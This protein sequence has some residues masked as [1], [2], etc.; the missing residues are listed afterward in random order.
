VANLISGANFRWWWGR[1]PYEVDSGDF[2]E[3]TTRRA[4]IE[5]AID[6]WNSRSRLKF[7]PHDADFHWVRFVSHPEACQSK[8][9]QQ[10]FPGPQEIRC[11]L[12]VT[13]FSRGA[14][15]HEMC[16][17]AGLFHEH[18]RPDRDDYVVVV[19][20]DETNYG[21]KDSDDVM[22]V[23]PYDYLSIMH[24]PNN[25]NLS[26]PSRYTPGQRL[27]LSYLDLFAL[28]LAHDV[29]RGDYWQLPA[30]HSMM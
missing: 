23:T 18:Q 11:Q 8:V 15:L 21:R 12:S 29:G 22:L 27:R 19:G 24:Y 13:G 26:A 25:A 17:A 16:H 9:G 20:G 3:G 14:V 30:E 5:W 7:V 6:H 28:E 1:I 10:F 4:K 2:P